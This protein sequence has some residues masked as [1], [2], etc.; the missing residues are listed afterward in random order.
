MTVRA[1]FQP[2]RG[3]NLVVSPAAGTASQSIDPIAKSIRFVNAGTNIC[4]VSVGRGTLSASTADT[5]ILPNSEFVMS[6]GDGDDV[7]AY[8][9]AL[10]TTLH[11][12]TGEGGF[13]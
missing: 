12:Q 3:A 2:R 1:A 9:S 10:G 11:I 4:H 5:P 8:I 7:V 13:R 6:K